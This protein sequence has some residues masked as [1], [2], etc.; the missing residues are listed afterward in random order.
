M[1]NSESDFKAA[2]A[3][4]TCRIR[5]A[6]PKARDKKL[7]SC[8]LPLKSAHE[9]KTKAQKR[10]KRAKRGPLEAD[11]NV[12]FGGQGQK[13]LLCALAEFMEAQDLAE[14]ATGIG[15]RDAQDLAILAS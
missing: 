10:Q 8:E 4:A 15:L 14:L 9:L 6:P 3:S 1:I 5:S 7:P 11:D 2:K 13:P 12:T